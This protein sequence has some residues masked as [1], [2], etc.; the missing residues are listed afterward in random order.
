MVAGCLRYD[1]HD[2]FIAASDAFLKAIAG[3][4]FPGGSRV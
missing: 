3:S 2:G 4:A 1:L